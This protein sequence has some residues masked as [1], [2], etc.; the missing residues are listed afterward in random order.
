MFTG[1][2]EDTGVVSFVR[3]GGDAFIGIKPSA[4]NVRSLKIGESVAV[5]GVCLT[6]VKAE[7]DAFFIQ[8]SRETFSKTTM[9]ETVEGTAVNLERSVAPD[10]LMGGHIVTGHIDGV[11]TVGSTVSRAGSVEFRFF[12]PGG[13]MKYVAPKGCIAINGV[14]LT[15]NEVTD[16]WFSVNVIPHTLSNT[17][18]SSLSAGDKVNFECDIVAK[19][20]ERLIGF[21]KG[22]SS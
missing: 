2:V 11:G 20:V 3:S 7:K 12:L 21:E 15:V 17:I 5:N 16:D 1:I 9:S 8:A 18:F 14:S 22:K 4:I 13:F 6:V 19:Y 10:G